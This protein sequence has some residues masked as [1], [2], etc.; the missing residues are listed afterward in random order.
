MAPSGESMKLRVSYFLVAIALPLALGATVRQEPHQAQQ[1]QD[2]QPQQAA[3][4]QQPAPAQT[5]QQAPPPAKAPAVVD[6]SAIRYSFGGNAAEIPATFL[7]NLIFIPMQL[8][9]GTPGFFLLDSTAATTSI[10]PSAAPGATGNALS[11]AVLK[12]PGV[13]VPMVTLPIVAHP[14]FAAQYGESVRGVLGRDFLARTVVEINYIRQTLRIYDPASF[15]YSGTGTSLPVTMT[16]AGPGLRAKFE[17][18]GHKG[19][20]AEFV[21]DTAVDY[22]FLFSRAFT[23]SQKISAARFHSQEA[24]DPQIDDGAKII[25][26]RVRAF[27]LKPFTVENAIGVFSQQNIN[28]VKDSKIAGGIGGGFLR[29]F[30]VTFD[31]PHQRV[32]LEPNLQINTLE[33]ADMS[34]LA[35]VA[36]GGNLRTF[37]VVGVQKGTPGH[38]AG[39]QVGDVISGVDDEPAADYTL[40]ELR[41][42]FQKTGNEAAGHS[43]KLLVDRNGQTLTL[44]MKMRRL[45]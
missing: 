22:A 16:P 6:P 36:K 43:Y 34:G 20:E 5:Q 28:G 40:A 13:Q 17:V 8:N 2:A 10:E 39:L 14:K 27:E 44:K 45:I 26:G 38:D 9:G 32:I 7:N 12:M 42:A 21:F 11:Y 31:L 33:D 23:D 29:R 4:A 35:I 19:Y 15:T 24:S 1:A 18:S 37:E 41:A 30:N 25:F 3:P